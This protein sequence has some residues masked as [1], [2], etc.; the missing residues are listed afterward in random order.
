VIRA[1]V[2]AGMVAAACAAV[3]APQPIEPR[4]V[5]E[6]VTVESDGWELAGTL[7]ADAAA[8]APQ[9][10]AILL[11][12]AAGSRAEYEVL[13][14]EL[15]ARGIAS[16]RLDLR[17]HGDST[18]LGTFIP[19]QR[20]TRVI[21]QD[22][23]RDV[24]AAFDVLA[25][26]D[27][28][29]ADRIAVLGASYSGERAARAYREDLMS[30]AAMVMMGPGDFSDESVDGVDESGIPWLFVASE[31]E[32]HWVGLVVDALR[33]RSATAEIRMLPGDAHASRIL[34]AHPE[35]NAEIADWIA[36]KL[37]AE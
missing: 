32:I 16:L 27:R 7:N 23:W 9:P 11:H 6:A 3:E 24:G 30:P 25:E 13:A 10:A 35:M 8:A 17:G 18:N 5:A 14:E 4:F 31:D 37:E 34:A 20:E 15:A 29:D 19:E 1:A 21:N 2:L 22:A 36:D 26:S 12:R 28:F 33:E